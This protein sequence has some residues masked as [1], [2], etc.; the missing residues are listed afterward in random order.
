MADRFATAVVLAELLTLHDTEIHS[1][2]FNEH[3]ETTFTQMEIDLRFQNTPK[4]M[5]QFVERKLS[6]LDAHAGSMFRNAM[7]A[8]TLD[9]VPTVSDWKV[10]FPP[11]IIQ[12]STN[13]Y[14]RPATSTTPTLMV[15]LL[16]LSR[17]MWM[18]EVPSNDGTKLRIQLATAVIGDVISS[19]LSR[20]RVGRYQFSDRYHIAIIGYHKRTANL[21]YS[22]RM[23]AGGGD[24]E[25]ETFMKHGIAPI[26]MWAHLQENVDNIGANFTRGIAERISLGPKNDEGETHTTQALTYVYNLLSQVIHNYEDCHPP[27][28]MHITDG[29]ATDVGEPAQDKARNEIFERITRL[30]TKYGSVLLSTAYIGEELFNTTASNQSP[31]D[32]TRQWT[33]VTDRTRFAG[34]RA[35]WG[36]SLR[37]L[38]SRMPD[39]YTKQMH[40]QGYTA[41]EKNTYLFFPGNNPE[42]L[43]LAINNAA[44][45]G[46]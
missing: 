16:D 42:M 34:R 33:G 12:Q 18:Y 9:L 1:L 5:M 22:E 20:C 35:E 10:I 17:S 40:E 43:S 11:P 27:Y 31:G 4:S 26:S 37:Q 14:E 46:K 29:A 13:E 3:K 19:L 8:N 30:R 7:Q 21:L 23:L 15:F 32:F 39:A 44:S 41:L 28:I 24:T 38:S 2:V 45:T 36:A 6:T 25:T